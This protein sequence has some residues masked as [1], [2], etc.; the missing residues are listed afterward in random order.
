[1]RRAEVQYRWCRAVD[2]Q[3]FILAKI[4]VTWLIHLQSKSPKS[5]QLAN[6]VR[7]STVNSIL[8][9]VSKLATT[10]W[11]SQSYSLSDAGTGWLVPW[12]RTVCPSY[13]L[14]SCS[15]LPRGT[16]SLFSQKLLYCGFITHHVFARVRPGTVRAPYHHHKISCV[17]FPIVLVFFLADRVT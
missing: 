10:A 1:M 9:L 3:H 15:H 17:Q 5:G 8:R 11:P 14:F 4:Q 13:L 2:P 12:W 16:S 7:Q 6:T